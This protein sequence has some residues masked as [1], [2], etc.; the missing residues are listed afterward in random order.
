MVQSKFE[1][2]FRVN[3]TYIDVSKKNASFLKIS[4][5]FVLTPLKKRTL[6]IDNIPNGDVIP[7]LKLI[8]LFYTR[9]SKLIIIYDLYNNKNKFFLIDKHIIVCLMLFLSLCPL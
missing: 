1:G 8:S 3:I 6:F 9:K 5:R 4:I 2:E 7:N